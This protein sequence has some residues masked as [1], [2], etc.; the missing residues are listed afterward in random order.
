[1][2]LQK[3][4][5]EKISTLKDSNNDLKAQVVKYKAENVALKIKIAS[6]EEAKEMP[7]IIETRETAAAE[8]A[9]NIEQEVKEQKQTRTCSWS[10]LKRNNKGNNNG[11]TYWQKFKKTLGIK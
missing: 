1:M 3:S 6:F 8:E 4:L 9:Q 10:L 5:I 11:T 7:L 2:E